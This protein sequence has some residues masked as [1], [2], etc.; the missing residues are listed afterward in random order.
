MFF[1]FLTHM[2]NFISIGCY[3][4]IYKL[5]FL[6]IILDYK[7]FKFKHLINDITINFFEKISSMECNLMANLSKF[8]SNKMILK[9]IVAINYNQVCSQTLKKKEKL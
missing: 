9:R 5:I 2:S 3:Y 7:N 4:L 8:T 1:M 6:Y